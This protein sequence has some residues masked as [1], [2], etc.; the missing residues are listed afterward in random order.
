MARKAEQVGSAEELLLPYERSGQS[1]EEAAHSLF[2]ASESDDLDDLDQPS[3]NEPAADDRRAEASR[4]EAAESEEDEPDE[5]F[6][7]DLDDEEFDEDPEEDFEDEEFDED[8]PDEEDS[9]EGESETYEVTLPG[10]EKAE[11]TLDELRAGYSRQADYTRKRQRDAEEHRRAMDSLRGVREEYDAKLAKLTETLE[12]MGPKKPDAA[13]RKTNPG[14]YAAQKAEYEEH[15]RYL[16]AIGS[17]RGTV[18]ESRQQE[19]LEV[20]QQIVAQERER[21]LDAVPEWREDTTRAQQ[22][23]AELAEFAVSTY[24]FTQEQLDSVVDHRLLLMLRENK[25]ARDRQT[26]GREK[27]EGKKRKARR[28]QPGSRTRT[29]KG[30]RPKT[31]AQRMRQQLARGGGGLRD[32]A[33]LLEMESGDDL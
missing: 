2:E 17:E 3:E 27:L 21:L 31:E 24:G 4:R 18:D 10:G 20:R 23:L 25:Q 29:R 22:E 13:L 14:E 6:D 1:A 19:M 7:E 32:H 26:K 11:V 30:A 33:R 12:E 15:Q 8:E 16:E 5:E 28:L 9:E